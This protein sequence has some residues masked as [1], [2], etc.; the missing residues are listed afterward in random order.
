MH[1]KLFLITMHSFSI[2]GTVLIQIGQPMINARFMKC[3]EVIGKH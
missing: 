3:E 1:V 2:S